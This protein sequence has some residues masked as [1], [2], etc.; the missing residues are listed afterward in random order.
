[1]ISNKF[2]IKMFSK[3][4]IIFVIIIHTSNARMIRMHRGSS[5]SCKIRIQNE[6][7][8]AINKYNELT[9]KLNGLITIKNCNTGYVFDYDNSI[10]DIVCTK[11]PV[12]HYR[13]KNN[14]TCL[15]C[16]EGF[17]SNEGSNLC[18][19]GNEKTLINTKFCPKG[20][21][22]GNNPYATYGNS[23]IK[24]NIE[25]KEYM[26]NENFDNKCLTCPSGSII[27]NNNC[28][29]CPIGS[30]EKNNK[31]I[32]C[33]IGTFNTIEGSTTCNI[34]NNQKSL[35]YYSIGGNNCD[36]SYL[37]SVANKVNEV[38]DMKKISEPIIY[39]AQIASGLI[40][41]N[42]KIIRDVSEF[43]SIVSGVSFSMY[44]IFAS[45]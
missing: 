27:K 41:T 34:C 5:C 23:C 19:K 8:E 14:S 2:K 18:I 44:M 35:A 16:P 9:D 11:C 3:K 15:H 13:T 4:L 20:T 37:F 12:N 21:I 42:R 17:S 24:C 26:P 43:V 36:D 1:M 25:N 28:F 7:D 45:P 39:S 31:C 32:E 29:K 33:N 38:V 6:R 40:Y 30:Y 22:I 10:D